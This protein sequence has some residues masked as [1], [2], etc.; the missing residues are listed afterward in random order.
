M[1]TG[2]R[3]PSLFQDPRTRLKL[4]WVRF[5]TRVKDFSSLIAYKYQAIK[6]PFPKPKLAL[7]T[8]GPT[9]NGIY[10]Q[11]YTAFADGDLDRLRGLC[12]DGL[13]SNFA[14]RLH[15]RPKGEK[16][17]WVLHKMRR[18]PRV[19]SDRATVI[20][21]I[22]NSALRQAVVKLATRQSLKK[23]AP[24]GR[25]V[26]GTDKPKDITEYLVIQKRTISGVEEKWEAWGTMQERD[27]RELLKPKKN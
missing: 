24:N 3:I 4:E 20:P 1:P 25:I 17:E 21:I 18:R 9:A 19:V 23:T 27:W 22:A 16:V 13:Y 12:A 10:K 8:I 5:R 15:T 14:S 11:M 6:K 7:R 26:S 2:P